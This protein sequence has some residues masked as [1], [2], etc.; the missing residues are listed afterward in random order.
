MFT[1]F[2]GHLLDGEPVVSIHPGNIVTV[3]T[4]KGSY[5]TRNVAISGGP[6]SSNLLTPLGLNLPLK[7]K[8]V[9][10]IMWLSSHIVHF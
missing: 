5:K 9:L 4:T 6:W 3:E 7:V 10:L 8:S 2:G 1:R